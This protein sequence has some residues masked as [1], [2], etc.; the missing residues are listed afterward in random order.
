MTENTEQAILENLK[1]LAQEL[2]AT[3][4]EMHKEF[5][6]VK[7][8]LESMRLEMLGIKKETQM[9]NE[10]ISAFQAR[11]DYLLEESRTPKGLE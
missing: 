3:R 4:E 5:A 6:S 9:H 2:A 11:I 7:N 10:E 1:T 8:Q